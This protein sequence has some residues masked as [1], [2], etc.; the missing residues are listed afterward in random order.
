[1]SVSTSTSTSTIDLFTIVNREID[2][3]LLADNM[4]IRPVLDVFA[5]IAPH[6][7]IWFKTTEFG[8]FPYVDV[9]IGA[10]IYKTDSRALASYE[11]RFS[12]IEEEQIAMVV[13]MKDDVSRFY[14]TGETPDPIKLGDRICVFTKEFKT[15]GESQVK[16]HIYDRTS[17]KQYLSGFIR[18][19]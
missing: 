11:Y 3:I 9:F 16:A 1:M 4:G 5:S 18:E 10:V 14:K 7:S 13:W 8:T 12:C 15:K 19:R 6:S 2:P 17:Y